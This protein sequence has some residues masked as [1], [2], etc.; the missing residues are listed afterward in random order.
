MKTI[1]FDGNRYCKKHNIILKHGLRPG[2]KYRLYKKGYYI[3]KAG[4]VSRC[5]VCLDEIK[6]SYY[7][8]S[9]F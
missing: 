7:G 9:L 6:D 1:Y 4:Y 3:S 8:K 5:D 2:F